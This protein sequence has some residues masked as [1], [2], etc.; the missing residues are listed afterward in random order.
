MSNDDPG[1][2]PDLICYAFDADPPPIVPA[3]GDRDWMDQT[4]QRAAYRCLPLS[5]ANTSGWEILCPFDF[6]AYWSGGADVS[7]IALTSHVEPRRLARLA[8]SHFGHGVLT[9]HVGYLFR[10]SPGWALWARGSPN[11]DKRRLVPLDGVV[12]TDWLPFS[13]T[14][15]WRFTR[16]GYA[17]FS[18][19]EPICFITLLPHAA[20]ERV[21]PVLCRLDDDP[22]LAA[23]HRAWV[24]SRK[25]F[26]DKLARLDE[27]TVAQGWQRLYVQGA[28]P[29]GAP[30]GYHLTKR[31]LK[32]PRP[33]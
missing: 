7:D 18:K 17:R 24:E 4:H 33:G 15:N 27:A 10:T 14:M 19:G 22:D 32:P 8:T 2:V 23:A 3:R 5:I 13:F 1:P 9:F 30:V 21:A 11:Q 31:N 29:D 16:P 12:E 6:Q 28:A 26:N 20:L 25:D